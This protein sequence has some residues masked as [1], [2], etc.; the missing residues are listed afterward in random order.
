M[1]E[2][3]AEVVVEGQWS[4]NFMEGG[5]VYTSNRTAQICVSSLSGHSDYDT[6]TDIEGEDE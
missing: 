1:A 6:E 2:A 3:V 4:V 5:H